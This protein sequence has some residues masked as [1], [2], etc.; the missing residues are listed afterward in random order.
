M[1]AQFN[2]INLPNQSIK[3]FVTL[4]D[5]SSNKKGLSSYSYNKIV[6]FKYSI[7]LKNSQIVLNIYHKNSNKN[8][9]NKTVLGSF[10]YQTSVKYSASD[11]TINS[12]K[13]S[14]LDNLV[15]GFLQKDYIYSIYKKN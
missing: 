11:I 8:H 13:K 15:F 3:L 6:I 2:S 7:S 10:L 1:K 9:F 14:D 4:I 5:Q 12:S